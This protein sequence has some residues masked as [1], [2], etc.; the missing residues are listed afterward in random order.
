MC[1]WCRSVLYYLQ[2]STGNMTCVTGLPPRMKIKQV[3]V[4]SDHVVVVTTERQVYSWGRGDK[5]QLGHGDCQ[6]QSSPRL[7][8]A[9]KGKSITMACCGD[10]FSAFSSDNGLVLTCGSGALGCLGHS[11]W[12]NALK[13]RLI[14][15]LLSVDVVAVSCGGHHMAVV[16]REGE[17]YCWG[18]GDKGQLGL[19]SEDNQC[20]PVRVGIEE[21][22]VIRDVQCGVDG[23][24]FI[25]DM[26]G[27]F[28]C[29]SNDFNKLGLNN[30]Q[31]FL[32]AMKNIFT[33]TEVEGRNVPTPVRA[34]ARHR[35]VAV[36]MGS[37]HSAVIVEAGHVYTFGR[38]T[39]GQLGT[40]NV[41]AFH[42]PVELKS[43]SHVS[44]HHVRCGDH[45]TVAS[46]RD[47][48][49]F[50]WG[51]R[52]TAAL[53]RPDDDNTDSSRSSINSLLADTEGGTVGEGG[54]EEVTPRNAPLPDT[55]DTG[56]SAA[57]KENSS[58]SPKCADAEHPTPAS[59]PSG[60]HG[61]SGVSMTTGGSREG[62][63]TGVNGDTLSDPG[64]GFRPLSDTMARRSLSAGSRDNTKEK[65][66]DKEK[67]AVADNSVILFEP[68]EIIRIKQG[69]EKVL[70]GNVFCHGENLFIQVETTAPPPRR[71]TFKK[72]S[73]RRRPQDTGRDPKQLSTS[74]HEAGDE[75]SSEA[76]EIDL[77]STMP[78]WL[79]EELTIGRE[80]GGR[81]ADNDD[82]GNEAD[83]TS[84]MTD[85][86][87]H[88]RAVIDSSMSSIH[89]NRVLTP[90][91]DIV[92]P[93]SNQT[94]RPTA[95][96]SKTQSRERTSSV[97]SC[98]SNPDRASGE[99]MSDS[100]STETAATRGCG[101]TP[102]DAAVSRTK[103]GSA[104]KVPPR[105]R[106]AGRGK[107][108]SHEDVLKERLTA[109]GFVSDVTVKR[110]EEALMCELERTREDKRRAEQQLQ[111]LQR[112]RELQEETLRREAE[113]L[114]K[115][116]EEQLVAEV[117]RLR[118]EL[119]AQSSQL[120]ERQQLV[121]HLQKQLDE[122]S[123]ETARPQSR[124]ARS[125]TATTSSV[126]RL[127]LPPSSPQ[128]LSSSSFSSSRRG[129]V[130]VRSTASSSKVCMLQ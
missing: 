94:F 98:E 70:L 37:H 42:A 45:Y 121:G 101:Q 79:R 85:D 23:T 57:G 82:D 27:V 124:Q 90:V 63:D 73:F 60:H 113:K 43:L 106:S 58:V 14:E 53:S 55:G 22:V 127:D 65:D 100:S 38:N 41:K 117:E 4:S 34:L 51:L 61:D 20:H 49:L 6:G 48:Q 119:Q 115:T 26:G 62:M 129:D 56:G 122:Q 66:R 15:A 32:M 81:C 87:T 46:S 71:R 39:E 3:G 64:A 5:G 69:H 36:A 84:D 89:V 130:S 128:P 77:R 103:G 95:Q 118:Q 31:G 40:T 44:I 52:Y 123:P 1:V 11:D 54:R 33:K 110:R 25:T 104:S 105:A 112:E 92:T 125:N 7:V 91:T 78:T 50:Y 74:S 59:M 2:S 72:R 96:H 116:R 93:R 108:K 35:V 17:V 29:G 67:D 107:N 18:Q 30:R 24:M 76:S 8:E 28:A 111:A 126:P 75:Y 88:C 10:D 68:T 47:H 13:P 12:S 114:A 9:L 19:G 86:D 97:N 99:H 16:E 109:R 102:T 120:A 21:G 83:N 80:E